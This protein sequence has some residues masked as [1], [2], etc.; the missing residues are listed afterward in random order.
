MHVINFY[1]R[2]VNW[3]ENQ[4]QYSRPAKDDFMQSDNA[5]AWVV[6]FAKVN[7][8]TVVTH[9]IYNAAIQRK[10][11]IPNVCKAFNILYCNTFDMLRNLNFQFQR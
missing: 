4:Q 11:P 7:T 10:L 2:I 8:L 3:A 5:D 9:E 6:A 1:I